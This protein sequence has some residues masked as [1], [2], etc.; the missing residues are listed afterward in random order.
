MDQAKGEMKGGPHTDYEENNLICRINNASILA[1]MK[2]KIMQWAVAK[3]PK[4]CISAHGIQFPSLLD[5]SSK[6]TLWQQSYFE[7]HI[8]P[9]IKPATSEKANTCSLFRL[10]VANDGQMPIKMY[11]EL[12]LTFWGL[13]CQMW[14]CQSC[15]NHTRCLIKNIKTKLPGIVGWNFIWL[16]YNTFVKEYGTTEF[17]S[18][19][20]PEGVVPLLF[21]QLCI[22]HYSDVPKNQTLWTTSGVMSW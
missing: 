7:T 1:E 12:D 17:D 4:V 20:C 13:K 21:S 14:M 10:T 6:A 9:K 11:T 8:L 18:F 16:S 15:K 19:K 22:F 5:S 3:C 2:T